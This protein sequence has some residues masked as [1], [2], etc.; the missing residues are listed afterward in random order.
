MLFI[1][2]KNSQTFINLGFTIHIRRSFPI[3]FSKHLRECL[4]M[5]QGPGNEQITIFASLLVCYLFKFSP[6]RPCT[7]V[8]RTGN[9][10]PIIMSSSLIGIESCSALCAAQR[11]KHRQ[12]VLLSWRCLGN[13]QRGEVSVDP[14]GAEALRYIN[15]RNS[16]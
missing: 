3:G 14:W 2:P 9:F 11:S 10:H 1:F 13:V 4:F 5:Q 12:L 16:L 15:G 7:G 8:T 6:P